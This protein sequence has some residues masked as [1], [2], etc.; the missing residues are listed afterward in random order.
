MLEIKNINV[1][2]SGK[3]SFDMVIECKATH[4]MFVTS[5]WIPDVPNL[6][7]LLTSAIS[8]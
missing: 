4:V 8:I 5:E 1:F 3:W 7:F 2:L 6:K